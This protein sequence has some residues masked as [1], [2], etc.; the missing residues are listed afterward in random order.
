MP[1]SWG[2]GGWQGPRR[3]R[4][5]G[6]TRQR[7]EARIAVKDIRHRLLQLFLTYPELINEFDLMIQERFTTSTND[8]SQAIIE[9]WSACQLDMD[10]CCGNSVSLLSRLSGSPKIDLYEQLLEDEFKM[11]TPIEGARLELRR[12]FL[13]LELEE[14]KMAMEQL[15]QSP[16]VD[17]DAYRACLNRQTNLNRLIQEVQKDEINYRVTVEHAEQQQK[18]R[19]NKPVTLSS[20]PIVR[21][22]QKKFAGVDDEN[23]DEPTRSKAS[24]KASEEPSMHTTL[25]AKRDDLKSALAQRKDQTATTASVWEESAPSPEDE[26]RRFEL[27]SAPM[28]SELDAEYLASLEEALANDAQVDDAAA[29]EETIDWEALDMTLPKDLK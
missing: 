16:N 20:H 9:V 13:E 23:S 2:Q 22:L 26:E 1:A 5:Y 29:W 8:L 15:A 6:Y 27:A 17:I 21:Q 18:E 28:P 12:T 25:S 19:R 24:D 4:G 7:P 14:I 3:S 11:T 10:H